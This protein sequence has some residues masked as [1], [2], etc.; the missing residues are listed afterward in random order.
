MPSG[1]G[2]THHDFLISEDSAEPSLSNARS[3]CAQF[4]LTD[5]EA[6]KVIKLI[7][8]VVDQWQAHFKLHEV[9]DKDIEELVAFIDSDDLLAERRNF[10]LQC[11]PSSHAVALLAQLRPDDL[12]PHGKSWPAVSGWPTQV[13]AQVP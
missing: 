2:A 1:N 4:D 3:V 7:I 9:T 6:V 12:K 13:D 10:E 5:G 11:H 8:A